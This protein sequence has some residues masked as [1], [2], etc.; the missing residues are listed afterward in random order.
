MSLLQP[1][2]GRHPTANARAAGL[3][4]A[5]QRPRSGLTATAH[6]TQRRR[7]AHLTQQSLPR[8]PPTKW[9]TKAQFWLAA[10]TWTDGAQCLL[11]RS[12]TAARAAKHQLCFQLDRVLRASLAGGATAPIQER[13][14]EKLCRGA[15]EILHR[16]GN[17]ADGR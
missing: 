3:L 4:P 17:Y 16:L 11:C 10:Y 8:P 14:E 9:L 15:S 7:F 1:P 13:S 5:L 2:E 12:L 6:R